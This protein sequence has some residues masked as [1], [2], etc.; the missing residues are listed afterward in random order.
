MNFIG[1]IRPLGL[2]FVLVFGACGGSA[3]QT[4]NI[5]TAVST[6]TTAPPSPSPLT[7][8]E[9]ALRFV[10][11]GQYTYI[12]VISRKD[13][14][15]ISPEDSKYL[16]TNAP[17][18]VDMALTDDKRRVVGGTNFNLEEGNLEMLKKRF[19]IEDYSAK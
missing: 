15:P 3:P 10:R 18:L 17:Q 1:P 9:E 2:I 4:A 7:D 19:V 6:P 12:Y 14:K 5:N 16:K 11:N 13:G 8:F